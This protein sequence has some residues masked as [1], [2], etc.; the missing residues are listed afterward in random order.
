MGQEENECPSPFPSPLPSPKRAYATEG[1]LPAGS[2]RAGRPEGRGR[3][4][5]VLEFGPDFSGI[6]NYLE[7]EIWIL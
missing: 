6:G 7:F 4:E 3:G 5:G 2:L 1:L